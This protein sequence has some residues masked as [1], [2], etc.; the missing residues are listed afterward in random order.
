MLVHSVVDG[1]PKEDG[2]CNGYGNVNNNVDTHVKVGGINVASSN[3][4]E[5]NKCKKKP[6]NLTKDKHKS[7]PKGS[8]PVM[9]ERPNKRSRIVFEEDFSNFN[10]MGRPLEEKVSGEAGSKFPEE[11]PAS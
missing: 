9:L 11:D 6:F 5:K 1:V 3:P 7:K 10:L 2:N 8:S 4:G